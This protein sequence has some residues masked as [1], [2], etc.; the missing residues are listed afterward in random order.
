MSDEYKLSDFYNVKLP[1]SSFSK[2]KINEFVEQ[3]ERIDLFNLSVSVLSYD[4]DLKGNH[5]LPVN[6][7]REIKEP[8]FSKIQHGGFIIPMVNIGLLR[9]DYYDSPTKYFR[10][11]HRYCKK[12]LPSQ[13]SPP[14]SFESAAYQAA[15]FRVTFS[16]EKHSTEFFRKSHANTKF[17][18]SAD[19]ISKDNWYISCKESGMKVVSPK[20]VSYQLKYYA[21]EYKYLATRIEDYYGNWVNYSYGG[22]YVSSISSNDGRSLSIDYVNK[23]GSDPK[24]TSKKIISKVTYGDREVSYL[25]N[26]SLGM[27][28]GGFYTIH[29]QKVLYPEGYYIDYKV[30]NKVGDILNPESKI[31][32]ID[33]NGRLLTSY[34]YKI[35][36]V[37]CGVSTYNGNNHNI[38]DG[39][40]DGVD[41]FCFHSQ[42]AN[43]HGGEI[44]YSL[45]EKEVQL[46]D[47]QSYITTFEFVPQKSNKD[48]DK[49]R[50]IQINYDDHSERVSFSTVLGSSFAERIKEETLSSDGSVIKTVDID[51]YEYTLSDAVHPVCEFYDN[52]EQVFI[53]SGGL[54]YAHVYE[55]SVLKSNKITQ[56]DNTYLSFHHDYTDYGSPKTI[57]YTGNREKRV[58]FEYFSDTDKWFLDMVKSK[59]IYY[60]KE[61]A[62]GYVEEYRFD[63]KRKSEGGFY[64][65]YKSYLYG[66]LFKKSEVNGEGNLTKLSLIPSEGKTLDVEYSEYKLGFPTK[67]LIPDR[68]GDNKKTSIFDV[69]SYG[70]LTY[71]K[72]FK[73]EE[74]KYSYDNLDR[75]TGINIVESGWLDTKFSWD[76]NNHTR[77]VERCMLN[78]E[79][80]CTDIAKVKTVETYDSL[81][82]LIKTQSTD[83]TTYADDSSNTKYQRFEYDYKDRQIFS[84]FESYSSGETNG[85]S[86]DYDALDRIK[87][88]SISGRGKTEYA[89]L[90]G[91]KI[92]VT[93]PLKNV[94]TT[95]YQAF[96]A[97]EYKIATFID[98]PE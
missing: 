35:N 87:S 1:Q 14:S 18:D 27:S 84:S 11:E 26:K 20:G 45:E 8:S 24:F 10:W 9:M 69:D 78:A 58:K 76:D 25:Y 83:N 81:L 88:V 90:A 89:Y 17:P 59:S 32:T 42:A 82:R 28:S 29:S 65:P 7:V 36:Y 37:I 57:S 60:D 85:T 41:N 43:E 71:S 6:I 95:T 79:N 63:Y 44:Y 67:I 34:K 80:E 48:A 94:T 15:N 21:K 61:E 68:Y 97:P 72:G 62:G 54:S 2:S 98:S 73:G 91:N 92:K 4:V 12:R 55:F 53:N 56:D 47:S 40:I 96:G 86:T 19:W 93:D 66:R 22:D 75:L 49:I 77:S 3:E 74:V 64:F 50:T 70:N 5:G 23:P 30:K 51:Y 39:S 31:L 52:C 33:Y 13:G 46:S 38:F 16:N